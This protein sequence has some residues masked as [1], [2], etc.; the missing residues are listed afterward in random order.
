MIVRFRKQR[1]HLVVRGLACGIAGEAFPAILQKFLRPA[2]IQ[3]LGDALTAA[4]RSD[5]LFAA[6]PFKD[7]VDLVF[8]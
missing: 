7:N 2:V 3:A 4:K 6:K 5:A 1:L 8:R